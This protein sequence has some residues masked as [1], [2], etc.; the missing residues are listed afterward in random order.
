MNESVNVFKQTV[1]MDLIVNKLTALQS[2]YNVNYDWTSTSNT[3][4]I[5]YSRIGAKD[6]E[7]VWKIKRITFDAAPTS[8][9]PIK[10]R[11]GGLSNAFV[12]K[13]TDRTTLTYD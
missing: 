8:G 4:Y 1:L 3:L 11:W 9:N 12:N 7:A 10:E 2:E 13:W 5:G 6:G